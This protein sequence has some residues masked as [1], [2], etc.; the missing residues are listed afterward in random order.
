MRL[1][2]VWLLFV[3]CL[4]VPAIAHAQT[5]TTTTTGVTITITNPQSLARVDA[6]G[7]AVT[8]RIAI[9][10][11]G[12]N[13]QDCLDNL[14]ILFPLVTVGFSTAE[15]FQIWGTDQSGADCTVATARSGATQTCYQINAN[16][17][18]TQTQTVQIPIKELTK[19]LPSVTDTGADGCRRVNNYAFTVFFLI[20]D[21]DS[22]TANASDTLQV[23]TIGPDALSNVRVLPGNNSV[24]IEWD[25]VGEAGADDVIGAQAFCDP[26]PQVA[27]AVDAGASIVCT[28]DAGGI[29]TGFDASDTDSLADAGVTCTEVQNEGGTTGGTPIP[30]VDSGIPSN[31]LACTTQAFTPD[32]GTVLVADNALINAFGCGSLTGSQGSTIRIDS[33]GGQPPSNDRVYAIAVAATDSFGNLGAVSAP[34]CQFPEETSDFWRTYRNEGGSAGGGFCS[35]EAP[36]FPGG[37]SALAV[38]GLALALSSAR[39]AHRA[40]RRR[41][42]RS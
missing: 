14:Q 19:G 5:T 18:R 13:L 16:F 15:T 41:R 37:T 10:P 23:D 34:I 9:Q 6:N 3:L 42:N 1:R 33:I 27:S 30:T 2:L 25:A 31:G 17:A 40:L 32:S 22:V 4:L 29:V 12:I 11:E 38:M 7:N 8:K 35:I 21:G 28:D 36:G 20:L 24:T 39:F 26:N